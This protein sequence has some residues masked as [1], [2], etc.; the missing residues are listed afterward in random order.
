[1]HVRGEL[2]R[3]DARLVSLHRPEHRH[4]K[5]EPDEHCVAD[6]RKLREAMERLRS[7]RTRRFDHRSIAQD[8][9]AD[10]HAASLG[11]VVLR[12]IEIDEEIVTEQEQRLALRDQLGDGG[13]HDCELRI[14]LRRAPPAPRI[15]RD[16]FFG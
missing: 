6:D 3:T 13:L 14:D 15:S 11:E 9:S 12:E 7:Q 10:P 1:M 16:T 2:Q 4:R 8:R 5:G